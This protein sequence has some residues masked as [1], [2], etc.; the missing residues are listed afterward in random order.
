MSACA[1]SSCAN[2]MSSCVL[3]SCTNGRSSFSPAS[4]TARCCGDAAR[5]APLPAVAVSVNKTTPC[6][7]ALALHSS[8][9]NCSLPSDLVFFKPI[10]PRVL[11]SGG[12]VLSQTPLPCG[13]F[14]LLHYIYIYIYT[15]TCTHNNNNNNNNDKLINNNKHTIIYVYVYIYIYIYIYTYIHV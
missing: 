5:H 9:R 13:R 14:N 8:R 7:R 10:L 4:C 3:A 2:G 6:R 15:H 11:S 1:Q 12:V